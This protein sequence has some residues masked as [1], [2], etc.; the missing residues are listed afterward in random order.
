[1]HLSRFNSN[2]AV[3][4]GAVVEQD[5][6]LALAEQTLVPIQCCLVNVL[7]LRRPVIMCGSEISFGNVNTENNLPSGVVHSGKVTAMLKLQQSE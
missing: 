3:D 4:D 7:A 1:M 5:N 2:H 6:V